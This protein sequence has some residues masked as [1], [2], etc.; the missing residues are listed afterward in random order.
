MRRMN[1]PMISRSNICYDMLSGH[2]DL[3]YLWSL[4]QALLKGETPYFGELVMDLKVL[5]VL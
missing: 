5:G 2:M 3:A 1:S 4:I